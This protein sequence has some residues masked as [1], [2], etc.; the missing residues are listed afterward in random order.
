MRAELYD[1]RWKRLL[2]DEEIIVQDDPPLQVLI[3][4]S[5]LPGGGYG[6]KAFLLVCRME[7]HLIYHELEC[8]YG[9]SLRK[10]P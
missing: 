10:A 3:C 2:K 5:D 7:D 6:M 9:P 4:E 8:G 1:S